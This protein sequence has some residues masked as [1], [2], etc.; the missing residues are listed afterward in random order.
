VGTHF[1]AIPVVDGN[2]D[3]LIVYEIRKRLGLFGLR[4]R[5]HMELCTG[6]AVEA[7]DGDGFVVLR[8]GEKL[9]RVAGESPPH[10]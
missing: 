10:A 2:G 7:F 3:Q 6:E 9:T 4:V 1:T 8:T 5:N